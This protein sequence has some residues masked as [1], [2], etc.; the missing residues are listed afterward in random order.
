MCVYVCVFNM[1]VLWHKCE[2]YSTYFRYILLHYNTWV[3]G[4]KTR[5]SDLVAIS[6]TYGVNI[7]TLLLR[8]K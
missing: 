1:D 8:S 5:W 2:S 6:F 3:L 7:L 4:I